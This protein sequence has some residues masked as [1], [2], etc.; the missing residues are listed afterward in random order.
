MNQKSGESKKEILGDRRIHPR[1][2]MRLSV[3]YSSA[4]EFFVDYSNNISVGGIFI[5]TL[6]PAEFGTKVLIEFTLPE[7][8]RK[9]K[10]LGEVVRVVRAGSSERDPAGMGIK[11]LK[12]DPGSEE[13]IRK[14]ISVQ[15]KN[16]PPA[17]KPGAPSTSG[18]QEEGK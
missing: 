3:K 14:F 6:E 7:I 17:A 10:G 12:F 1:I 2:P 13:H 8:P 16:P 9:V 18:T 5:R 4:K 15:V 11:F